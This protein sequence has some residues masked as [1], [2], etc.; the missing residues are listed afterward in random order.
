VLKVLVSVGRSVGRPV[1][2]SLVWFLRGRRLEQAIVVAASRLR[3]RRRRRRRIVARLSSAVRSRETCRS[4]ADDATCLCVV[5]MT[6]RRPTMDSYDYE[7][8]DGEGSF[9]WSFRKTGTM[10]TATNQAELVSADG[11]GRGSPHSAAGG[12]GYSPR[13]ILRL[14]MQNPAI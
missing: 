9:Q 4:S 12:L 7:E 8:Y 6:P 13:K 3:L 10:G 1:E 14:H 5:A 2:P 11:Y